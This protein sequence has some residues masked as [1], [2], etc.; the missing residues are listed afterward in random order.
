MS[1]TIAQ[2]FFLNDVIGVVKSPTPLRDLSSG[3]KNV[4]LGMRLSKQNEWGTNQ[5]H[6]VL[7]PQFK[8]EISKQVR[9]RQE[10]I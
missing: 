5:S 8:L 4:L 9:F 1:K 7:I 2:S 6:V 10:K 3:E